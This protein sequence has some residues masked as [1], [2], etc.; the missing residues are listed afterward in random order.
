MAAPYKP[1]RGGPRNA[2]ADRIAR[3]LGWLSIGVSV[4][5]IF[6]PRAISRIVGLPVT[7]TLTRLRGVGE[8]ASGFAILTQPQQRPSGLNMRIAGDALDLALLA[9]AAALSKSRRPRLSVSMAAI[10]GIAALDVYCSRKLI[11]QR[12]PPPRHIHAAITVKRPAH[13]LYGFWRNLQNLPA[14]MPH[15]SAVDV[16]DDHHSRWA[17]RGPNGRAIE[18]ESEIIDDRPG[19]CLAWR[20]LEHSHVYNAGSVQFAPLP[21]NQGTLVSVELLY[22][23]PAGTFGSSLAKLVGKG[24]HNEIR[25]DLAHF[26]SLM[27]GA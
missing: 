20:S 7:P 12:K 16:L 21:G 15:L 3:G 25:A 6:A 10:A 14:V 26:K 5:R 24:A 17:A 27:E 18:W 13:E 11:E 23:P 2:Q 4:V 9:L 8:L 19:E 22:D 1:R